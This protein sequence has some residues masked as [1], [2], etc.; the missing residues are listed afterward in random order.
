MS[1]ASGLRALAAVAAV[2][3]L[4]GAGRTRAE[5]LADAI[6]LAYQSNPNLQ[7]QRASVRATD[8]LYV[9][10][11]AGYRP[12]ASIQAQING[13]TST[14]VFSQTITGDST[15]TGAVLSVTQPLYTGGR[16]ASQVTTAQA[17]VFAARAALRQTEQQVLQAVVQAYCDVR[18]DQESVAITQEDV[19]LL[20]RQLVESRARFEVGEITRTDVA[21]TEAR[22]A[23]AQAQLSTAQAVLANSRASYNSVVGK[24]PENLAPE[25]SLTNLLPASVDQAFTAAEHNNPQVVQA[26]YTEQASAAKVAAAKAQMRPTLGLQ[27]SVGGQGGSFGY[28]SPFTNFGYAYSASA[29]ATVPLF[30]GGMT[31]SQ[32]RQAAENDNIDRIGIETT[33]RQVLLQVSQ[34]W[35]ALLG[36]RAEL[37][38]N[39]E[40]VRAAN[41]AFE[42]TRQEAQVGL[43]TTL[44][45]LISEQ[46]LGNAQ[47]AL[48]NARHDEYVAS[49]ALL[50][51][52]GSLYVEDLTKNVQ[53][54]DPT[55]NFKQVSHAWATPLDPVIATVDR[56]GAPR[57]IQR[58]APVPPAPDPAAPDPASPV[59]TA[60]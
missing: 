38:A 7:A 30:T 19:D 52:M 48:V 47:L 3:A 59:S 55:K 60:R 53:I 22:V 39:Q 12:T 57:V 18:R 15:A 5:T 40:A 35:N 50:A 46:D 14:E 44:D 2:A 51:A 29:V 21:Q 20:Q 11:M 6:A 25:P 4:A 1:A 49:T 17:Q 28:N 37:V 36:S 58:P 31:S 24:N 45:V 13:S 8:E 54:Y 26:D 56:I 23:A 41:I 27:A 33:R 10:A 9:Q 43:R 34:A 42:G 16:V 32:I